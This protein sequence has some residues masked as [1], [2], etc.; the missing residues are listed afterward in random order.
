MSLIVR[1]LDASQDLSLAP[2]SHDF[3]FDYA[4]LLATVYISADVPI[5][6]EVTIT[7]ISKTGTSYNTVIDSKVLSEESSYV[8]AASGDIAIN[9]GDKLR[10]EVTDANGI[11][12]VF[13]TVKVKK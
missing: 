11:G 8:F 7:F 10:V 4:A 1:D 2:F 5:T 9:E 3:V 13:V 12:E 6:E